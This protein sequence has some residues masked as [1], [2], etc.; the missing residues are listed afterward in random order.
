MRFTFGGAMGSTIYGEDLK[1]LAGHAPFGNGQCV[2]LPQALTK[3]GHTSTW[4][5]G[6]R[7]MDFECSSPGTVLA[8]FVYQPGFLRRPAHY[9]G[10]HAALFVGYSPYRQTSGEP[11]GST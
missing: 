10:Y 9:Q 6:L 2:A 3:I 5:T 8:N 11:I 7:L 1:A 4:N